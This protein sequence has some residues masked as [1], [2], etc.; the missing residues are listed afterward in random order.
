MK[1]QE[2][3]FSDDERGG[4]LVFVS[5]ATADRKQAL[6]VCKSVESRGVT[7]WISSRDVAPG[8]NYQEAIV[9]SLRTARAMAL[10]FSGAAN[11]SEE[12]KKELSLASR[13][14]VP[15]M[16]LRIEDVEPSDAFAYE[17]S[18][19]QW[20]DA[21]EDWD[22]ALDVLVIRVGQLSDAPPGDAMPVA[23][24]PRRN[25]RFAPSSTAM[26]AAGLLL[27]ALVGGIWWWLRPTPA[28][29]HSMT[30]RMAGFKA[31]A[32][33]L[34]STLGETIEIEIA[35]AFNAD[36]V[37]GVSTAT[38]PTAGKAPAYGLG[39]TILRDGG[40]IRV[41]T[42]LTNERSGADLWSNTFSYDGSEVAK[43]PHRVAV[44]AGN[45]IR[46]GLF[47][48]S[49][50]HRPLPD[51]VLRDYLQ[52]CQGHW[53]TNLNDGREALVPAQRV[54]AAAPDFSWGWAAVAG[55]YWKVAFT[56]DKQVAEA[57]RESG[58]HA[59]DRA[60][61]LDN[62]NSEA[63][64]I[65]SLLID[66]Q[67]W[68]GREALLK[69][70]IAARS[71]DCG[72]EHH[73]YGDMLVDAG[74]IANGVEQLRQANDMLALYVYTPWSLAKALIVEGRPEE[75][76]PHIRL[77]MNLAP[78]AQFASEIAAS[79]AM[80]NGDVQALLD[81]KLPIPAARRVALVKGYRAVESGDVGAKSAAVQALLALPQADQG[82]PTAILLGALGANHEAF[83]IAQRMVTVGGANP[84]LLWYPSMRGALDDPA[85]PALIQQLGLLQYWKA[86]KTKPDVCQ[87]KNA[88]AFCRM[89]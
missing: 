88:P 85:F 61:A 76:K 44:D 1:R 55:A 39:G 7:C 87:N 50:Y 73:Q 24:A 77:A 79:A 75:A 27:L 45:V 82:I 78:D 35:A 46:C 13:F 32:A 5:F 6:A 25:G 18:T 67:D 62:K 47:G 33:G 30:V 17:L 23:A 84:S 15:V 59:A 52:F 11:N 54:V 3:K 56:D 71:L 20:I 57:A 28:S 60:I 49:T 19:R 65:K 83:L 21:F 40:K 51:K 14:R 2:P 16:A 70:A 31:L 66:P 80:R 12:I 22:R 63:L 37:V 9:R 36:G 64:W 34:P 48:A 89:I 26:V 86:S 74:R 53:D 29:A 41:I 81:P 69:R 68:I 10:V 72:C 42:R 58:R 43:V 8:D 38:A 4:P